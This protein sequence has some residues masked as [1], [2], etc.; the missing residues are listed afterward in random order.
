M[1]MLRIFLFTVLLHLTA[2]LHAQTWPA[3]T[4]RVIAPF[5]AGGT[6]DLL[7]RITSGK[8]SEKIGRA[9]V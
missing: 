6:A 1:S 5:A 7:G 9:H 4:V 8:L 3:R 2:S